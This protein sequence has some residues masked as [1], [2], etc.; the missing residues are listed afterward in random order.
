MASCHEKVNKKENLR[1]SN[2]AMKGSISNLMPSIDTVN[3]RE[4]G[5]GTEKNANMLVT[6][7]PQML[8]S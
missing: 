3:R 5:V 2:M 7:L 1:A 6:L 8:S 4:R